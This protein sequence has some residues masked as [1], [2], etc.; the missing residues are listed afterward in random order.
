M[1]TP[2][3]TPTRCCL[4]LA[5]FLVGASGIQV[6][7]QNKSQNRRQI[8][9]LKR[10][11]AKRFQGQRRGRE[12][13]RNQG[14]NKGQNNRQVQ[15]QK[16]SQNGNKGQNNR[17][18]QGQNK[19]QHFGGGGH[20]KL[21]V[22]ANAVRIGGG[23]ISVGAIIRD[24][25]QRLPG[26][27]LKLSSN[28]RSKSTEISHGKYR[29]H[30]NAWLGNSQVYVKVTK[31]GRKR[32]MAQGFDSAQVRER[33]PSPDPVIGPGPPPPPQQQL[34][35]I[36]RTFHPLTK[37]QLTSQSFVKRDGALNWYNNRRQNWWVFTYS[38]FQ[39]KPTG[40]YRGSRAVCER[41]ARNTSRDLLKHAKALPPKVTFQTVR[42]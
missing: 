8:T 29:Y 5:T 21:Y 42:R 15:G 35:Y 7:A 34:T 6:S 41:V 14:G 38:T 10:Q 37:K 27:L 11:I 3:I 20:G 13:S 18:V 30:V 33:N 25:G 2:L 16:K 39:S 26:P 23:V 36:V 24:R 31:Y 4:L 12:K 9:D 40:E 22:N 19:S 32:K 1:N 28:R 17:Q